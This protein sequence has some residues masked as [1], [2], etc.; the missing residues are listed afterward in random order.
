MVEIPPQCSLAAKRITQAADIVAEL[1]LYELAYMRPLL[2][3]LA[4]ISVIDACQRGG[5]YPVQA[6]IADMLVSQLFQKAYSSREHALR[7]IASQ[8]LQ[9]QK[10][11]ILAA[12]RSNH[13]TFIKLGGL[14]RQLHRITQTLICME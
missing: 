2:L 3:K 8:R 4:Y 10:H 12:E 9:L 14:G 5:V 13:Y 1:P 6:S 7:V 11:G